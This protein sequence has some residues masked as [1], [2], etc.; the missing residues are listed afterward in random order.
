TDTAASPLA[1]SLKIDGLDLAGSGLNQHAPAL[2]GILS[3]TGDV[4][5]DGTMAHI[6]GKIRA[7]KLRLARDGTPAAKPVEFDFAADHNLRR[8]A[9]RLSRGEIHIGA[10]PASLT[11]TYAPAG[12]SYA[13][14]MNLDASSM[15]V[16]ELSAM[17]PAM[18]VVLPRGSSLKGGTASAKIS[19]QGPLDR[20]VTAGTL[21]LDNTTLANFDM[22]RKL[23]FIAGLAGIRT[24]GDT[25]IQTLGA[26]VQYGPDGGKV[27][28][29]QLIVPS[30]GNLDGAGTVSP[31]N[32]LAFQMRATVKGLAVP[33]TVAGPATEPSFRP[34]VKGMAKDEVRGLL[35]GIL[36]GK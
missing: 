8:R 11:G 17:L 21:A 25:A 2:A 36:G 33:F 16:D 4:R 6:R 7:E 12:D 30:I 32:D 26:N 19:V 34:D 3:L 35:K 20:L 31:A 23:S 1:A 13:L 10:A 18:N 9:G 14:D 29:L 15:A 28:N 5:G 24:S 27:D 22:G